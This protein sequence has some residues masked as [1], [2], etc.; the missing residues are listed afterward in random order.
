[1]RKLATSQFGMAIGNLGTE[2]FD[3]ACFDYTYNKEPLYKYAYQ[4]LDTALTYEDSIVHP[5]AKAFYQSKIDILDEIDNFNPYDTE[6][7]VESIL[8]KID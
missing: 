8:K 7:N 2:I 6:Y 3:Y 5:N 4:L 1:M